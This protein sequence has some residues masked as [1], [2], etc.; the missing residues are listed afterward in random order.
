MM[1]HMLPLLP[2]LVCAVMLFG[3]GAILRLASR[4]PLGRLAWFER[5]ARRAHR[6]PADVDALSR[7]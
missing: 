5:R 1:S 3:T 4:T 6:E 2:M 7:S